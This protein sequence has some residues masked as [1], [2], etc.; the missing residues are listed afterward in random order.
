MELFLALAT[1]IVATATLFLAYAAR[2]GLDAYEGRLNKAEQNV[3]GLTSVQQELKRAAAVGQAAAQD[4]PQLRKAIQELAELHEADKRNQADEVKTVSQLHAQVTAASKDHGARLDSLTQRAADHDSRLNSLDR[5]A[6]DVARSLGNLAAGAARL[7]EEA[8]QQAAALRALSDTTTSASERKAE[9]LARLSDQLLA[10]AG[11]VGLLDLDRRELRAQLRKWLAHSAQE[12]RMAPDTRVMPGFI[13]AER[14]AAGQILPCLYEALL[15]RAKLDSVFREQAGAAGVFYYLISR[16]SDG[17]P[18]E[19]QLGSLLAACQIP[20]SGSELPGLA[21]LRSLLLA[22]YVGGPATMRL[23]PL[24]VSH[25]AGG[26]FRG[27]V[28]TAGEA[29]T[30]DAGDPTSSPI[31]FSR[32]LGELPSDC[33]LDLAAWAASNSGISP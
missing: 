18:A 16:S 19:Q 11:D 30:L 27:T 22:M 12:T 31:W 7:K 8:S 29:Q 5:L 20:D 14:H 9:A 21:E 15:Q 10:L 4:V 33:V 13:Q 32:L 26:T 24:V 2:R 23:G 28:L 3:A 25:S 17:Q 1:V 6:Q